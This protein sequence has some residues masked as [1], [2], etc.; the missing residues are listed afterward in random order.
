MRST[1]AQ[2]SSRRRRWSKVRSAN[3]RRRRPQPSRTAIIARSRLPLSVSAS[4]D[5]HKARASVADNQ[6][7]SRIPSFF[8]PLT[9]RI[10]AANSGLSKP[11]SAASYANRRIAASRTL[12]VPGAKISGF[13]VHSVT[14]YDS[15]VERESRF[16]TI[17]FDELIDG[18]LVT[19]LRFRRP[20]TSDHSSFG[21]IEIRQ[22]QSC[23]RP[24]DLSVFWFSSF[25]FHAQQP[26]KRLGRRMRTKSCGRGRLRGYT[27]NEN[28]LPLLIGSLKSQPVSFLPV[29]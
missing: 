26:P 4:G 19:T 20:Q 27:A 11:A 14:Q 9:R 12:I 21:L 29:L 10:P 2:C 3:S 18:V 25:C 5:R 7:P 22:A 17:P 16:R 6:F 28:H 23:F 24:P 1:I 13:Q 8:A 15:S